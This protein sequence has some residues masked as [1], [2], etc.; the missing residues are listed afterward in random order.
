[1]S[2]SPFMGDLVTCPA[3]FMGRSQNEHVIGRG[4]VGLNRKPALVLMG[5]IAVG[6]VGR[7]GRPS[8]GERERTSEKISA[9]GE[10]SSWSR[11]A[12]M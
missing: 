4:A 8:A 5:R 1:M 2:L 9:E 7:N 3:S 11:T 6:A 10:E 12:R